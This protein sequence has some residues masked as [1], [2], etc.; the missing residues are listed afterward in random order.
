MERIWLIVNH[1]VESS[2]FKDLYGLLSSSFRS[3]GAMLEVRTTCEIISII[4][5]RRRGEDWP[6]KMVFWDKDVILAKYLS[7]LGIQLFNSATAI[8]MCDNK[9]L[10]ALALSKVGIRMPLTVPAPK[11]FEGVG[12][13]RTDFI[14][15]ATDLLGYPIIIKEAYGSFGHQV[16]YAPNYEAACEIVH[17]IGHRDF[18]FQEFVASS[19][20]KDVRVNVVGGR[21]VAAM[22]R[23]NRHDFRSNISNGGTMVKYEPSTAQIDIAV[24]AALAIG[25]DF[26]G[27]DVMFGPNGIPLI[28][29]V[30]SNPHFRS[31]LDCTGVNMADYIADLVIGRP[32]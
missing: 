9:A 2:K 21:C 8:E 30:N 19:F 6:C 7:E 28:C 27:V 4:N 1:F 5:E 10:T 11:T 12:Y 15:R 31:T 23:M 14:V 24:K 3:R 25:L 29:E 22:M 16:Y 18:I 32:L 20:G 13:S 26:A 17:K